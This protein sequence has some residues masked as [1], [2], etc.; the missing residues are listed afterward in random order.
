MP[1]NNDVWAVIETDNAGRTKRLG[2]ELASA[3]AKL[4][5][6]YGGQAGAV[7]IGPREA[8]EVVG[9]YGVELPS[10]QRLR[11]IPLEG[12]NAV[13]YIPMGTATPPVVEVRDEHG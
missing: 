10:G 5:G 12:H 3:A 2:L 4:A 8:A 6:Q 11:I 1:T 9:Q 13:N 7:V